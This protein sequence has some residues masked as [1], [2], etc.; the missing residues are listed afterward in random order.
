[1]KTVS[2]T[3]ELARVMEDAGLGEIRSRLA[4]GEGGLRVTG[5][6]G[7]ARTLFEAVLA[8]RQAGPVLLV[9]SHERR[10]AEASADV[11][12]F[13]SLLG[14]DREGFPFPALEVDPYRGLSPHFDITAARAR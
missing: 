13:F 2:E 3:S 6:M 5:L 12:S 11:R 14:V 8:A 9:V 4:R 10:V 1:M 7:P